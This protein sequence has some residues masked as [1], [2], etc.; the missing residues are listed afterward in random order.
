MRILYFSL[1]SN[2]TEIFRKYVGDPKNARK[3]HQPAADL[4]R[5]YDPHRPSYFSRKF[6][7]LG[8]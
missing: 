8:A 7:I 2:M 4:V 6:Q 3:H 5:H 1:S